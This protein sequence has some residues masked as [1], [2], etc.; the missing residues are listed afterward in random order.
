MFKIRRGNS[1]K[2]PYVDETWCRKIAFHVEY[3]YSF[4]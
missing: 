4:G 3:Y 2:V 1:Q